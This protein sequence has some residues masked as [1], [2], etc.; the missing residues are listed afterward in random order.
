MSE[1]FLTMT[2]AWV[3]THTGKRWDLTNPRP[4]DVDVNDIAHSLAYQVRWNGHCHRWYSIAEH[5]C[6]VADTVQH[7]TSD[8]GAA[9]LGLYHDASEAYLSDIPGPLKPLLRDYQEIERRHDEVIAEALG[10]RREFADVVKIADRWVQYWEANLLFPDSEHLREWMRAEWQAIS[11]YRDQLIAPIFRL[12]GPERSL[13]HF[14]SHSS[15][16]RPLM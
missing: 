1:P 15:Y 11:R 14:Q 12:D 6:H 9:E 13:V 7:L 3:L 8:P 2:E 10:L 16:M 5:C 4:G